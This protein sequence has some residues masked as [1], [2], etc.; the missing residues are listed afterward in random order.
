MPV[1]AWTMRYRS[2]FRNFRI[3]EQSS[4]SISS[5]SYITDV[6]S[7]SHP[8]KNAHKVLDILKNNFFLVSPLLTGI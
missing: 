3:S 7:W 6:A 1:M 4:N 8:L 2:Y 5:Y